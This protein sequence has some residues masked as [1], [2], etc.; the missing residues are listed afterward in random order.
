MIV[1][2]GVG[3]FVAA[4]IAVAYVFCKW[5]I[6]IIWQDGYFSTHLWAT[7]VTFILSAIFCTVFILLIKQE[8]T[9]DYIARMTNSQPMMAPE[10][11][12]SFFFIP[13]IYWPVIL[14]LSGLGICIYDLMK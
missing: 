5:T 13:I 11:T 14:F 9:L 10:K 3:F 1:W 8:K 2:K 6:N 7:G 4:L 12:H